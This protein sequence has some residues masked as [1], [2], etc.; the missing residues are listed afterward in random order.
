M[1]R[2]HRFPV[3]LFTQIEN[4]ARMGSVPVSLIINQLLGCGLEAVKKELPEQV[5]KELSFITQEQVERPTKSS[6]VDI[7]W[8]K[9]TGRAKPKSR[10]TKK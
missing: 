8:D 10:P 3:M 7:K 6:K 9:E 1:Q 5:V 2:S 4:M